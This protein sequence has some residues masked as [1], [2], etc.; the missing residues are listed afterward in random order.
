MMKPSQPKKQKP[1]E[2]LETNPGVDVGDEI[3]VQHRAGPR[4]GR[5]VAHGEHG[6]TVELDGKH[7]KVHWKHVLGAK[8]RAVQHYNVVEEGEDGVI[9][10]DSNGRRRFLNIAPEAREDKMVVKALD[11]HR[12]VLFSKS[13][14]PFS[15]RPG[16]RKEERTDK[17]GN[18]NTKWV[19]VN[20]DEPKKAAPGMHVGFVNGEHKGHGEVTRAGE[21]G[22]T[23]RDRADG[24]HRLPHDTITHHWE[25]NGTPDHS[26]HDAPDETG[27]MGGAPAD[28][29]GGKGAQPKHADEIAR[30][31]FNTSELDKLPDKAYQPVDSWEQLSEKAPEALKEFKGMLDGVAKSLN[32]VTGKR[33]QS[34]SHAQADE[35]GK[36]KK[37]GR[38]PKDLNGDEYMLPE[39]WDDQHGY[40]FMGPL[41]GE[42]RA[43]E[44]VAA[45]YKGDWS[46]VR[47]MVRATIAVPKVTQIP[48]VLAELKAQGM[49]LAQKPKNNL[50]KPLP[51][52][53]RDV[54]LI[55]KMPNGLLAELQIHIKPMTLA[56]EQGHEPYEVSRSIQAKYK[57][58]NLED[59]PE[60]WDPADRETHAKAMKQQE[61][62]YNPAWEKASSSEGGD[63]AE[64]PQQ[65][66]SKL[67]KA[68]NGRIVFLYKKGGQK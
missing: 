21:G 66:D 56:K 31:L 8:K 6:A 33:P 60:K 43:R 44:K 49:E 41:K 62:L 13:V 7:H 68:F 57:E 47:D 50:V 14:V 55:V 3:Y 46:Q 67:T 18:R 35:A 58:K 37:E 64:P 10:E 39:H 11:G 26:P 36:A 63:E 17:N 45:D 51:G 22:L 59:E 27:D 42:A 34:L 23:V 19:R 20:A 15:G 9:V 2:Q 32:L 5:V 65:D 4:S 30:A 54:N 48:K 28:D 25:G 24:I 16:L 1:A 40:L 53:Y 38:A 29:A 12:L 52:G 61:D